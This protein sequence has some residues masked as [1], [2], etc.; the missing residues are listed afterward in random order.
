MITN[1][2]GGGGPVPSLTAQ[3]VS[4]LPN[5]SIADHTF[6]RAS[7]GTQQKP[8]VRTPFGFGM[9]VYFFFMQIRGPSPQQGKVKTY[10]G[11]YVSKKICLAQNYQPHHTQTLITCPR[12]GSFTLFLQ[13]P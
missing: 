10:V 11:I 9:R 6:K 8:R 5:G 2:P 12:C 13:F 4:F 7:R 1:T 3:Q